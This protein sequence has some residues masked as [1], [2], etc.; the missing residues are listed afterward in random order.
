M[1]LASVWS[2][3][4]GID[5]IGIDDNFFELGG[6]SFKAIRTA[7]ACSDTLTLIDFFK[8]PTIRGLAAHLRQKSGSPTQLL[9]ELTQPS[10]GAKL[11]L[12]CVP[13][14]GGNAISYQPLA[15]SL[16]KGY[17]LYSVALPGHDFVHRNE[18]LLPL[19]T[20]ANDC[21]EEIIRMMNNEPLALYGQCAGV[22]LTIEIARLLEQRNIPIK[23]IYLGAALPDREPVRSIEFER[24]ISDEEMLEW[25]RWLG[26][27]EDILDPQEIKHIINTVRHDLVNA[28]NYYSWAYSSQL[29]KLRSP[30]FCIIG[31]EDAATRNYGTRFQEWSYFGEPVELTVLEGAGHYFVKHNAS[32]L[33]RIISGI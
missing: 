8:H 17:S 30:I 1:S 5:Q 2:A 32:E 4:L 29:E 21:V 20:V 27:F 15:N 7:R 11:S 3:I 22:A 18:P 6:D 23:A 12:V 31:T 16:P 9:Y 25:L 24:G 19:E 10:T 28:A 13:Y 33:A 26:G 14:G